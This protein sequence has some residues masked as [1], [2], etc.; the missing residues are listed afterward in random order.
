MQLIPWWSRILP[1]LCHKSAWALWPCWWMMMMMMMMMMMFRMSD[2]NVIQIEGN[3]WSG[4]YFIF[5]RWTIVQLEKHKGQGEFIQS[6]LRTE[7]AITLRAAECYADN[8]T[9]WSHRAWLVDRFMYDKK[10]VIWFH[11]CLTHKLLN[12]LSSKS[13]QHQFSPCNINA[14]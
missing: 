14:L 9:A 4:F 10:K 11:T 13:D 3:T 1:P 6:Y 12:P 7:L 5:R 8:Y 2:D